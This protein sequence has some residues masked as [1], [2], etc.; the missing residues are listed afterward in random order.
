MYNKTKL[1][2]IC[3]L[4]LAGIVRADDRSRAILDAL[5]TTLNGQPYEVLFSASM[6]GEFEQQEGR[7]VVSGD[8]YYVY[9]S[10]L[11]VFFDGKLLQTYSST[12]NQL[13]LE[14]LDP[15]DSF[16]LAS[17]SRFFRFSPNDIADT[18]KGESVVAGRKL[19]EVLLTP[20][21][22]KAGYESLSIWIDPAN[23]M[24]TRLSA[25]FPGIS[26]PVEIQIRKITPGFG[27]EPALFVFDKSKH[28]GVEVIDFR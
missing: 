21:S 2:L 7:I 13:I 18:Y 10:Q 24:P 26:T 8:K 22:S 5:A 11:E 23:G 28:K 16:I 14:T 15:N 17:P 12:E 4:L 9:T 20:K 27:A 3:S 19:Q 6:P 1:L 25:R